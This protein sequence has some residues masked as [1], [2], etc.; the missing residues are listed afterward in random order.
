MTKRKEIADWAIVVNYDK[1]SVWG[2]ENSDHFKILN[3]DN[4]HDHIF[5]S[6]DS[7]LDEIEKEDK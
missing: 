7:Y 6:V 2:V 1:D 3:Q 5:S 4:L